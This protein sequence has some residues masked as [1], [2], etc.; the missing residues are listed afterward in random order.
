MIKRSCFIFTNYNNS[1][2]SKDVVK[3]IRSLDLKKD[4]KIILV[5]NA[6]NNKQREELDKI[7]KVYKNVHIIYNNPNVGYFRGLNI[8]ISYARANWP[9]YQ[10]FIIGNNDL[11]FPKSFLKRLLDKKHLFLK[12]PVVSPNIITIDGIYQNPHVIKRISKVREFFYSLYHFNYVLARI[13]VKLAQ[14]TIRISDR[15]DEE[16]HKV[17]QEIYQGYGACYILGPLFFKH[18]NQLWAPSFLMYEEFFLSKQLLDKGLK[19]YYEPS[20][21]LTHAAHASTGKLSNKQMWLYSRQSYK[22]YREYI[23]IFSNKIQSE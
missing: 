13:I 2:F 11:I 3:S 18:F 7:K 19:I 6:S 14:L 22:I 20:I 21:G 17:S 1:S 9:R 8:G 5:D 23:N 10:Y 12:Y 16:A 15:K 4:I